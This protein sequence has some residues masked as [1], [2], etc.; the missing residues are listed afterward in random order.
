[1]ETNSSMS[2]N[3][4]TNSYPPFGHV[5]NLKRSGCPLSTQSFL[6][7]KYFLVKVSF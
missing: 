5:F 3:I 6:P 2:D 1:M 7:L 4:L